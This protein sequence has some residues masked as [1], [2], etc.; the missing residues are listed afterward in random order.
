MKKLKRLFASLLV[1]AT[2]VSCQTFKTSDFAIMVKLP[3]TE[4]CFEYHVMSGKEV[5]YGPAMCAEM[6][7][8]A[9]FLTSENWR[10][11]KGDIQSNCQYAECKQISGAADGLFF[12][13]DRAL[14]V[15]LR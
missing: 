1:L 11:L 7:K 14:Q 10:I 3:A 15:P 13:I 9:I 6:M 4:N 2:S 12:A 8:R 5:E